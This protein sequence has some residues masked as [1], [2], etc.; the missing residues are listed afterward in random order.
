LYSVAK[1]LEKIRQKLD[2]DQR[3]KVEEQV[4]A[5]IKGTPPGA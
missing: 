5:L 1:N 3:R 2:E 4:F